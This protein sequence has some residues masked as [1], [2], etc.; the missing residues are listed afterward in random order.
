MIIRSVANLSSEVNGVAPGE[1]P[2]LPIAVQRHVRQNPAPETQDFARYSLCLWFR[3]TVRPAVS[4][5]A[6]KDAGSLHCQTASLAKNVTAH[7]VWCDFF[8]WGVC[9]R[10][11]VGTYCN[12][13]SRSSCWGLCQYILTPHQCLGDGFSSI[14]VPNDITKIILLCWEWSKTSVGY[15][16]FP[17][18]QHREIVH[19]QV[20]F[21]CNEEQ[22]S[23]RRNPPV[24]KDRTPKKG[25]AD[26]NIQGKSAG[27]RR[28][29]CTIIT[30]HYERK[31]CVEQCDLSNALNR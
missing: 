28:D 13:W 23:R 21:T 24:A 25:Q 6:R 4:V 3:V 26:E 15:K 30:Q 10:L 1:H 22:W 29:E 11:R 8:D 17:S 27:R 14:N 7:D 31:K 18:Q 12:V 9:C 16:I 20:C 5:C 19:M 2:H